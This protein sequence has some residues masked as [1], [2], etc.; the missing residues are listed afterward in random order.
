MC[1]TAGPVSQWH[2]AMV[3][4]LGD[5]GPQGSGQSALSVGTFLCAV[6]SS[7]LSDCG[8]FFLAFIQEC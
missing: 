6:L 1:N 3:P 8:D 2:R 4:D 7:D 5:L